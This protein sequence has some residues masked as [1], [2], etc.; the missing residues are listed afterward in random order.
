MRLAALDFG[1]NS[2]RLLIAEVYRNKSGIVIVPEVNLACVTQL[3]ALLHNE[4]IITGKSF[5]DSATVLK[6]Y[7]SVIKEHNVK[8]SF[9]LATSVFRD[10]KNALEIKREFEKILG[11]PIEIISGQEE[12]KLMFKGISVN[13]TF[14]DRKRYLCIDIGGGSTEILLSMGSSILNFTSFPIGCLRTRNEFLHHDPPKKQEI[15]AMYSHIDNLLRGKFASSEN[16]EN[17]FAFGGTVTTFAK[18]I[19]GKGTVNIMETE[20]IVVTKEN[21][22]DFLNRSHDLN[23]AQIGDKYR[24]YIDTQRETVFR[25]GILILNKLM[26]CFS[27][28]EITVTN[29]GILYGI[30]CNKFEQLLN[31]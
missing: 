25:T 10:S 2:L 17:F 30:L 31:Y 22:S 15:E 26:N 24:I 23:N 13:R 7:I 1:T 11:F 6:K 3:G 29:Q 19:S 4:K 9:A 14:D 12:A 18:I 20:D 28:K 27:K 8:S 16:I 5:Q 21:V